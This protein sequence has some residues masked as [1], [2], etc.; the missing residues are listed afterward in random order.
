MAIFTLSYAHSRRRKVI[1]NPI[2]RDSPLSTVF[3]NNQEDGTERA[4]DQSRQWLPV[5]AQRPD[6]YSYSYWPDPLHDLETMA[7][8]DRETSFIYAQHET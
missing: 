2:G 3:L 4:A 8:D 7:N 5:K 1:G 6:E